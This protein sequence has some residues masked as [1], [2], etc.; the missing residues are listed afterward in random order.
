MI[1]VTR[2]TQRKFYYA[3]WYPIHRIFL[4]L[5]PGLENPPDRFFG[6]ELA[7]LYEENRLK[8][9]ASIW[10]QAQRVV[11]KIQVCYVRLDSHVIWISRPKK[12]VYLEMREILIRGLSPC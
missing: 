10:Q 2:K 3:L 8:H 9:S 7:D 11:N 1:I 4:Q 5:I 6:L 12:V